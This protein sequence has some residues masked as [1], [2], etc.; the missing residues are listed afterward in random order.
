MKKI[1]MLITALLIALGLCLLLGGC[2][3]T[4]ECEHRFGEWQI[5]SEVSCITDGYKS[6]VCELC[7]RFEES[8]E[9]AT[10]HVGELICEVC[11]NAAVTPEQLFPI[12]NPSEKLKITIS[13]LTFMQEEDGFDRNRITLTLGEAYL[14]AE[15][16]SLSGYARGSLRVENLL[17]GRVTDRAVTAIVSGEHIFLR[18]E[19]AFGNNSTREEA[20]IAKIPLSEIFPEAVAEYIADLVAIR[21]VGEDIRSWYAE[22]FTPIF[23]DIAFEIYSSDIENAVFDLLSQLLTVK[24]SEGGGK[25]VSVSL[26]PLLK[27]HNRF[28][29]ARVSE[30]IDEVWGEGSYSRLLG[31]IPDILGYSVREL[32]EY[33]S[34]THGIDLGRLLGAMDG[35]TEIITDGELDSLEELIGFTG[36]LD[37]YLTDDSLLD[38]RVVD[39]I[40]RNTA[41]ANESTAQSAVTGYTEQLAT[42]GIYDLLLP[43]G[44]TVEDI[45]RFITDLI[46]GYSATVTLGADG[47]YVNTV[48]EITLP[49]HL[50]KDYVSTV[51]ATTDKEGTVLEIRGRNLSATVALSLPESIPVTEGELEKIRTELE[52]IPSLTDTLLEKIGFYVTYGESGALTEVYQSELGTE[53]RESGLATEAVY[54]INEIKTVYLTDRIGA[55]YTRQGC[56]SIIEVTLLCP[57]LTENRSYRFVKVYGEDGALISSTR[58]EVLASGDHFAIETE[59]GVGKIRFLY[60]TESGKIFSEDGDLCHSYVLTS[61]TEQNA[62]CGGVYTERYACSECSHTLERHYVKGHALSG[63]YNTVKVADGFVYGKQCATCGGTVAERTLYTDTD[64]TLTHYPSEDYAFSFS[65]VPEAGAES[66]KMQISAEGF[67]EVMVYAVTDEG[68][69]RVKYHFTSLT[70]TVDSE[71]TQYVVMTHFA[72]SEGTL[73]ISELSE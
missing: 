50:G 68:L 25:S 4:G 13:E 72:S 36:E 54:I 53:R 27:L 69:T 31:S 42:V 9:D 57:T 41:I 61:T 34:I 48:T 32:K 65:F 7:G 58:D 55:V 3:G 20:Y 21:E 70:L 6:R 66:Y 46:S 5:K 39:V 38:T 30:L 51:K 52:K 40:I 45:E 62:V 60:D 28:K 11:G 49:Y 73:R 56:G 8:T 2:S 43:K 24:K 18:G 19:G 59:A 71:V 15:H 64:V 33:L 26:T 16:S 63:E 44:Y 17:S 47:A 67:T 37:R 10:G 14:S 1:P 22:D 35:L 29:T 12:L 23:S